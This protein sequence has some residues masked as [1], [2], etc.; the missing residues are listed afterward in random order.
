ML[1]FQSLFSTAGAGPGELSELLGRGLM[2]VG[3]RKLAVV[4]P[5]WPTSEHEVEISADGAR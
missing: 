2:E 5:D 4:R 1:S 3:I